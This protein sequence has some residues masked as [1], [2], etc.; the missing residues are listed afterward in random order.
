MEEAKEKTVE[1]EFSGKW[2]GAQL[3]D[4]SLEEEVGCQADKLDLHIHKMGCS[5]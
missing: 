1:L 4:R 3:K 2:V 5:H